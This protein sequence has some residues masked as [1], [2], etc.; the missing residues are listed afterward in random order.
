VS[1]TDV[2]RRAHHASLHLRVP[3][4]RYLRYIADRDSIPISG[5]IAAIIAG[6][7]EAALQDRRSVKKARQHFTIQ[8]E[9][10]ELLDRLAARLGL[11]RSDMMRRLIDH[12]MGERTLETV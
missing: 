6:H 2:P 3:H 5:A 8:E 12:A 4:V 11:T 7:A 10:M 9:H 1:V